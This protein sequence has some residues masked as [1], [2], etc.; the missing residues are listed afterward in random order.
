MI[1]GCDPIWRD[2][3]QVASLT[4]TKLYSEMVFSD[5]RNEWSIAS[6]RTYVSINSLMVNGGLSPRLPLPSFNCRPLED[7][8]EP[9]RS[10]SLGG[11]SVVE[12]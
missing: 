9:F 6:P 1:D 12:R 4:I 2:D 8:H 3:A 11:G 5:M 7:C 10:P